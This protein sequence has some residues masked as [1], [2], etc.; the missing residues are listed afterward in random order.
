MCFR[1]LTDI[2]T[3]PLLIGVLAL[4]YSTV[5]IADESNRT[6]FSKV[7]EESGREN[8]W[9]AM[10]I[11]MGSLLSYG[12]VIKSRKALFLGEAIGVFVWIGMWILF[13]GEAGSSPVVLS[14]AVFALSLALCMWRE[15]TFGCR[16]MGYKEARQ[17]I[18]GISDLRSPA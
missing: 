13:S 2:R 12:A 3:T 9:M 15:V 7:L 5:P 16:V 1:R 6:L 18:T 8:W 4:I 14:F 11:V 10:L 17:Q